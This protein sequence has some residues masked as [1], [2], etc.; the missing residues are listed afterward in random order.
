MG[1]ITKFIRIVNMDEWIKKNMITLVI[2][3]FFLALG[4]AI[5]DEVKNGELNNSR[6]I[7]ECGVCICPEQ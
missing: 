4:Y 2:L 5:Y 7:P 6:R 3:L 1:N